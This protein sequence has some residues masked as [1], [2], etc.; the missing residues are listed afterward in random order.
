[1]VAIGAMGI[2]YECA[3]TALRILSISVENLHEVAA[4]Q[5]DHGDVRRTKGDSRL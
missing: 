1:M 3:N 5:R 2:P 4:Q